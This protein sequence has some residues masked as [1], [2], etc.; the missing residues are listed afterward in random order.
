MQITTRKKLT[1]NKNK[2]FNKVIKYLDG[3]LDSIE[4]QPKST[5]LQTLKKLYNDNL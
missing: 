3:F 1:K 5:L 4:Y 2:Q